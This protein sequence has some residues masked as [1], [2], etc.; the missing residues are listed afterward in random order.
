MKTICFETFNNIQNTISKGSKQILNLYHCLIQWYGT[1]LLSDVKNNLHVI[2]YYNITI[3]APPKLGNCSLNVTGKTV[4]N[5]E[6]LTAANVH[7][8]QLD[9]YS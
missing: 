5:T 2:E 7:P 1:I 6:F 8:V 9:L 3:F 4:F